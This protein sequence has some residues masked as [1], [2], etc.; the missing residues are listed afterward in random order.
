MSRVPLS[1]SERR[2]ILLVAAVALAVTGAGVFSTCTG[3]WLQPVPDPPTAVVADSLSALQADSLK[4][5]KSKSKRKKEKGSKSRKSGKS[6][7]EE[8]TYPSRNFL[9]D[10]VPRK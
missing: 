10:T 8:R 5:E 7:R 1:S 9:D 3:R 2:G 6:G 4:A